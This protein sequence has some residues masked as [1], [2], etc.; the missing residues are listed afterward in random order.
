MGIIA[1]FVRTCKVNI[2]YR[3]I[4]ELQTDSAA[5]QIVSGYIHVFQREVPDKCRTFVCTG[6]ASEKARAHR[7]FT[8]DRQVGDSM[9]SS[10]EGAGKCEIRMRD[11]RIF[12]RVRQGLVPSM[13]ITAAVARRLET[14]Q[15]V[16][17][18]CGD[19]VMVFASDAA[20]NVFLMK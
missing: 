18:I 6:C 13:E 11:L 7:R 4:H 1:V 16:R 19:S 5:N 10:V 2:R 12:R 20:G 14:Q 15:E 3:A 9:A 17:E 8:G